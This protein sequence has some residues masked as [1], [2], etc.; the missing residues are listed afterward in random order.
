MIDLIPW[1]DETYIVELGRLFFSDSEQTS[2]L[3]NENGIAMRPFFYIGPCLQELL[4]RAFGQT[5]VRIS[6]FVGLLTMSILFRKWLTGNKLLSRFSINALFLIALTA[7]LPFLSANMCRIDTWALACIFASL[8][9]L[10]RP[11]HTRGNGQI[12]AAGFFAA[13]SIYIWP[14]AIVVFPIYL[15]FGF[16]RTNLR[17]YLRFGLS[18]AVFATVLAIPLISD[19]GNVTR[20]F[21]QHTRETADSTISSVSILSNILKEIL[22]APLFM[23]LSGIGTI[24]WIHQRRRPALLAFLTAATFIAC[25]RFYTFRIIYLTPFLLLH[26]EAAATWMQCAVPRLNR[27]L[28]LSAVFIGFVCGPIGNLFLTHSTLPANLKDSLASAIGTGPI[29]V[30]SPDYA[31]YY[32]GRELKWNQTGFSCPS[33]ADSPEMIQ[34]ALSQADFV[35][36]REWD[37]YEQQQ[38]SFSPLWLFGRAL[39]RA[40]KNE[41]TIANSEKSFW[42]RLGSSC[43]TVWHQPLSPAGFVEVE[44]FGFIVVYKRS[45]TYFADRAGSRTPTRKQSGFPR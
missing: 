10:G 44:R 3:I 22:R 38:L 21:L 24:T 31:T 33:S 16:N 42:A 18:T 12:L 20:A 39:L 2:I 14:T 8:A 30:F 7:P 34:S 23:T 36:L 17:E 15:A 29:Q 4:Y 5:A 1:L 45:T 28:L 40:A 27:T 32:I 6:P 35:I 19:L 43:I 37:P 11:D 13:L 25:T 9:T 26:C 41:A